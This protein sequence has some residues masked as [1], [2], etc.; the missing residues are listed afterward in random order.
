MPASGIRRH[1]LFRS[2]RP[3]GA[4]RKESKS[5]LRRP[6]FRST[7]PRGARQGS[8]R[9]AAGGDCFDPRAREGRDTAAGSTAPTTAAFRSTRPR[10]ARR[11]CSGCRRSARPFRSTRPRGARRCGQQ[12][13]G[14]WTRVSIHAPARGATCAT[15]HSSPSDSSFDPRAREGRDLR[16]HPNVIAWGMF[17]STRPRGARQTPERAGRVTEDVS[18]HAPARGATSRRHHL[19]ARRHRFDPRAR[20]G[21]DPTRGTQKARTHGFDP[22]AREGRDESWQRVGYGE[23]VFRSTRPRGARPRRGR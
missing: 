8:P 2:T 13:D 18:I 22:R 20:E 1:V 23:T 9:S 12:R 6:P 3:R 4:R 10:G 5:L 15:P 19:R 11:A 14:T 16:T 7:R 17:R 21:R